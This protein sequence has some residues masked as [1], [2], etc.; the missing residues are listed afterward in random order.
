MASWNRDPDARSDSN[1]PGAVEVQDSHSRCAGLTRFFSI[2]SVGA[3]M[4]CA[5]YVSFP[6][7]DR[8]SQERSKLLKQE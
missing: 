7:I 8:I 4:E 5:A 2:Q 3:H 1:A 6:Q